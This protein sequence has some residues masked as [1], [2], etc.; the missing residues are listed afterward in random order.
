MP[1]INDIHE[2][3]EFL[4]DN[5]SI[6][7]TGAHAK[8]RIKQALQ[9]AVDIANKNIFEAAFASTKVEDIREF[10]K[11]LSNKSS[12]ITKGMK[13]TEE[14][15][16]NKL[17]SSDVLIIHPDDVYGLRLTQKFLD[18][19]AR[20]VQITPRKIPIQSISVA[21]NTEIYVVEYIKHLLFNAPIKFDIAR[22][23]T[24]EISGVYSNDR[25]FNLFKDVTKGRMHDDLYEYLVYFF[26]FYFIHNSASVHNRICFYDR[27]RM[28]NSDVTWDTQQVTSL[29]KF[30]QTKVPTNILH[31][32]SGKSFPLDEVEILNKF[33]NI[34]GTASYNIRVLTEPAQIAS[35]YNNGPRSC[36]KRKFIGMEVNGKEMRMNPTAVYGMS[37]NV[38]LIVGYN[39]YSRPVG[40]AV[41]NL[42]T[43]EYTR[44]YG[45]HAFTQQIQ[46]LGYVNA[47]KAL[48]GCRFPYV[49]TTY[50]ED[51]FVFPYLDGTQSLSYDYSD[52][53]LPIVIGYTEEIPLVSFG[54]A[55]SQS[56]RVIAPKVEC[57][58]CNAKLRIPDITLFITSSQE[59]DFI[60]DSCATTMGYELD[61]EKGIYYENNCKNFEDSSEEDDSASDES[62]KES[63]QDQCVLAF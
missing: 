2:A 29:V 45:P 16:I 7:G 48:E 4:Q 49:K 36:M 31:T 9:I 62:D 1:K 27:E 43:K 12:L 3:I 55:T 5:T 38:G 37:P 17:G 40:R 6:K 51:S 13:S 10:I 56:G 33:H 47:H 22:E 28:Q 11:Y 15:I 59:R 52:P 50:W 18:N 30:L 34:L 54:S 24:R 46:S 61:P 8:K 32:S 25:F 41:V 42:D 26:K 19:T 58:I 14:L 53:E 20:I 57:H 23:Y 39:N 63:D 21:A 60:C 35:V 44:V